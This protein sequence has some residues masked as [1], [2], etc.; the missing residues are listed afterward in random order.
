MKKMYKDE[1]E[2][3][4]DNAQVGFMQES[5]W[6]LEKPEEKPVEE[7]VEDQPVEPKK[8]I[9]RTPKKK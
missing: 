6:S 3:T 2:I 9:K 5:G 4:V 7:V 1:A 8:I